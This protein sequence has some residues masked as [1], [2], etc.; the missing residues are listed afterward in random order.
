[1][2][3][4]NINTNDETQE[5]LKETATLDCKNCEEYKMGWQRATA[6]YQNLVRE[7]SKQKSEWMQMIKGNILEDF[8]PVYDNFKKAFAYEVSDPTQFENW[9]K[10]IEYIMKQFGDIVK[11]NGVEEIK[12]VG[13]MFDARFHEIVGEEDSETARE[14]E[15]I[16]EMDGGYKSGDK[17]LKVAKVIVA[18]AKE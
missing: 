16:R 9:K 10:G 8:I 15:I 6:D 13:E 17:V 3:D 5:E 1:M 2:S 12:T 14:H 18:K 7:T 11:Q 4:E